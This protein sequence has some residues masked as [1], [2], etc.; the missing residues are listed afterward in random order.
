MIAKHMVKR[1]MTYATVDDVRCE[2]I[3]ELNDVSQLF[4]FDE[5]SY[6][7]A[8]LAQKL[9]TT[10]HDKLLDTVFPPDDKGALAMERAFILNAAA[11]GDWMVGYST[12]DHLFA[13]EEKND[14]CGELP[15]QLSWKSYISLLNTR[16]SAPG[17]LSKEIKSVSWRVLEYLFEISCLEQ[18][19]SHVAKI[20]DPELTLEASPRIQDASRQR[21]V[22][23]QAAMFLAINC[24]AALSHDKVT[25]V[26]DH[27]P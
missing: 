7:V 26:M 12:C 17:P 4:E 2:R 10:N 3:V 20:F 5:C 15:E 22:L 18:I 23:S 11:D 21:R 13:N 1:T 25:N 6:N 9:D 19:A 16:D 27:I 14:T 24:E 8:H